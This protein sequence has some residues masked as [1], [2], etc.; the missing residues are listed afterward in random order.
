MKVEKVSILGAG[1]SGVGAAKLAVKKGMVPFVSD[2]GT[3]AP[4]FRDALDDQGVAWE[5][6]QHTPKRI[7]DAQLIIKS[8]GIP[9]NAPIVKLCREKGIPVIGEIEFAQQFTDAI[10]VGV[11]GSNGKTTT[12][13]LIYHVLANAGRD[14]GLVGNVGHSF[15]GMVAEENHDCYVLELSSF[16]LE[17]MYNF[18]THI[19]VMLNITPDHL[20]RYNYV[21]QNY[22]NAKFRIL[23]NQLPADSFVYWAKDPI[24][25]N[26]MT[27]QMT[28]AQLYPFDAT[29]APDIKAFVDEADDG[30]IKVCVKNHVSTI[31]SR[32]ELTL[33]GLHNLYN[34]I[35]AATV[36]KILGVEDRLIAEGLQTFKGVEHRLEFVAKVDGV[37]YVNDSKSTN[38]NSCFYA[39]Q[40]FDKIVLILGGTDKGNDYN[41]ILQLVK[42]KTRA[43][44]FLGVD[45]SKLHSFFDGQVGVTADA[46]SMDEAIVLAKKFAQPGD[47]VLLSPCCASFDLFKNYED[48]GVQFKQCVVNLIKK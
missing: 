25:S 15:A 8:P 7:L 36:T 14:V 13:K 12:S 27:K 21:M 37:D 31:I 43:L 11:T 5:D 28:K 35:A 45:N 44:V 29:K 1:E 24:I 47:T 6:G 2:C 9:Q 40:S 39:L 38:V 16:Q 4:N 41:E 3:I 23:Q 46:R 20:D 19:A 17:D 34:S 18:R 30:M 32:N 26:E 10:T 48:R 42:D 33:K 22:V